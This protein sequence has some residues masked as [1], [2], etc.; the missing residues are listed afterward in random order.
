MSAFRSSLDQPS[1]RFVEF[2]Q[3]EREH[4]REAF[5]RLAYAKHVLKVLSLPTKVAICVGAEK[6]KVEHGGQPGARNRGR[7]AIVSIPPDASRAHIAIALAKLA[8]RELDPYVL[9][10]LLHTRPA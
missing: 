8:G 6:L 1:K 2:V 7:W 4:D 9:D 10:T 5:N 3:D